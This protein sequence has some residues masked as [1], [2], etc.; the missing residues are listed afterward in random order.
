[1]PRSGKALTTGYRFTWSPS[2]SR[3]NLE[4]FRDGQRIGSHA[5]PMLHAPW[6]AAGSAS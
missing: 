1:M 4:P 5:P 6:P 3:T 2:G